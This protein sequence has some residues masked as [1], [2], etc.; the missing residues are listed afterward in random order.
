[1]RRG[2]VAQGYLLAGEVAFRLSGRTWIRI[3]AATRL[4][5]NVLY[6]SL[7]R[8]VT[9]RSRCQLTQQ[10]LIAFG[11]AWSRDWTSQMTK[12]RESLVGGRQQVRPSHH[13]RVLKVGGINCHPGEECGGGGGGCH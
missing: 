13:R 3:V 7:T 12:K 4:S 11:V 6:S 2:E 5:V 9:T 1:V 8:L 10:T